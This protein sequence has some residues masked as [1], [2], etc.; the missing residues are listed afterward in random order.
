MQSKRLI[1]EVS[2]TPLIGTWPRA[3]VWDTS[4]V[5]WQRPHPADCPASWFPCCGLTVTPSPQMFILETLLSHV[6]AVSL[7]VTLHI[8]PP[9]FPPAHARG[10]LVP[11]SP[12]AL[13]TLAMWPLCPR[14]S[15]AKTGRSDL[16]GS[17]CEM[18]W[19]ALASGALRILGAKSGSCHLPCF[20][21]QPVV[22]PRTPAVPTLCC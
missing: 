15:P 12:G 13:P 17:P 7:H 4:F 11:L 2:V 20:P 21:P 3:D 16:M 6:A 1:D 10:Q 14:L 22:H 19:L 18:L 5:I 8:P 9:V